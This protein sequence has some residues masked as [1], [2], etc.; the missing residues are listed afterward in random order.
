MSFP[1]QTYHLRGCVN[2]DGC[3]SKPQ[4]PLTS[5][6]EGGVKMDAVLNLSVL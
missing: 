6:T 4:R 1:F 5:D 2:R 3:G